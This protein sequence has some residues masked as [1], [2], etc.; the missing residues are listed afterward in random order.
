[1]RILIAGGGTGGHFYPA[2]AMIDGFRK[3][4]PGAKIGYVGTRHG[5]E[6]RL[7]PHYPDVRF[8]PVHGRGLARGRRWAYPLA[9]LHLLIAFFEVFIVYVRFRPQLV[10]GMG[11]YS[12]FAPVFLGAVLG[13]LFPIRTLIHEQ[14][15][16]PG[17]ANRILSRF[18]DAVLVSYPQTKRGFPRAR[19]IVVTGTPVREG[20]FRSRRTEGAYR[21][22]GLDPERRTVLVFGGS[23]GS[24]RLVE[25][26]L[27]AKDTL[28]DGMQV[29]LVLGSAADE[30]AIRAELERAG[31]ADGQVVEGVAALEIRETARQ[32]KPVTQ[33]GVGGGFQIAGRGNMVIEDDQ[34]VVI[35]Y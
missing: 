9:F 12:S 3:E 20:F 5:I 2:L 18:V 21:G 35:G 26:I 14:N 33:V 19:R 27:R 28:G 16:I 17:L 4:V 23:L 10:I 6:A 29:L 1:M 15:A 32:N 11:N 31:L 13:R 24:A 22:F 7:L 25:G 30:G 34:F 8:F